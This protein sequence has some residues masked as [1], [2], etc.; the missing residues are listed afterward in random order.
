MHWTEIDM[1]DGKPLSL[2]LRDAGGA[3]GMRF[4][5]A[6]EGLWAEGTGS[7]C[8][9]EDVLEMRFAPGELR[10]G[11]AAHWL[12]RH[13][14]K[15]GGKFSFARSRSGELKV[16]AKGWSGRFVPEAEPNDGGVTRVRDRHE[17]ATKLP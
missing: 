8:L 12:L 2:V 3:L 7:V 13:A 15:R 5:K 10:A 1:D 6:R 14:L 9:V 4:D 11:P 17:S 16:T